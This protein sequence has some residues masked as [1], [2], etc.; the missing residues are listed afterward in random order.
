MITSDSRLEGHRETFSLLACVTTMKM[1][2]GL[3][4]LPI[5]LLLFLPLM[6]IGITLGLVALVLGLLPI[7]LGILGF[8]GTVFWL[9]MLAHAIL[10]DRL[11]GGTRLAWVLAVW[12]LP[13]IGAT[14]YCFI[15]RHGD[16]RLLT[17]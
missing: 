12:F 14:F 15:G 2:V 7:G 17:V 8:L 5:K 4:L 13:F 11:S 1:L 3:I 16:R 6:A 10:N 9:W